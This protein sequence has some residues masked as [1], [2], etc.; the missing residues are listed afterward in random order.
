MLKIMIVDDDYIISESLNA[1]L[2]D[3]GYEVVGVVASGEEAVEMVPELK[4]DLILMDIV[5]RGGMDGTEAARKIMRLVDCAVVFITGYGTDEIVQRAINVEPHGYLLKPFEPNEVKASIEI[6][7]HKMQVENRLKKAYAEVLSKLKERTSELEASNHQLKALLNA[8]S[9]SM[10]LLDLEGTVLAGNPTVAKRFGMEVEKFI[11][12]CIYDLMPKDLAKARKPKI[13]RVIRTGKPT[14]FTDKR[15]KVVF[16]N[17]IY[18]IFDNAGKVIQLAAH[19]KDITREVESVRK[20]EEGKRELETKTELLE[21]ANMA[22][23]MM[24]QKSAENREE[25]EEEVLSTLKKMVVPYISKIKKAEISADV[26]EYLET[27]ETNLKHVAS[28]FT[29]KL[30]YEYIAL[31]PKEIQV[32]NLIRDGKSTKEISE[33]LNMTKGS[34]EFYRNNIRDKIGLRGK[35]I[36]LR[37]HLLTLRKTK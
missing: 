25:I 13:D 4:P 1:I 5:M 8:P 21:Q 7:F 31:T 35:K 20:L 17:S 22:L 16:D 28:P 33:E 12:K 29:R 24:L 19:G 2:P 27:L 6:A 15:G 37:E 34:T 3:L 11:G 26:K 9:D 30:S 18:P 14:R 23:K 32:A 10:A 36:R